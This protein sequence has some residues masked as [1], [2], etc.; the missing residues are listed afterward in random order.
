MYIKLT[1]INSKK[2][3]EITNMKDQTIQN[4]LSQ[5]KE[6]L[7]KLNKS[8]NTISSYISDLEQYFAKYPTISRENI[9]KYKMTISNLGTTTINRKLTSLKQYN[10]YLFNTNQANEMY[11]LKADYIR[12]QDKGNPTNVSEKDVLKFLERVIA[13]DHIYKSRNIAIIYLMANTGIRREECCN[14]EIANIDLYNYEMKII[15]KGN[16]ERTVDL[17]QKAVDVINAYLL[18]RNKHK[19]ANS[20]YLFLSERAMKLSKETINDIFDEYSTPKCKINPHSLRHNWCSTMLENGILSLVEVK[21]QAGHKSL[22]TTELYTHARH[23][24]IKQKIKNY[25]IG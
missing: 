3:K 17:N 10:E 24:K 15:G 21:N 14:L 25:S 1:N 2:V 20:P 13:K 6:Y 9:T 22:C 4:Q 23:D 5:Y 7:T 16:K 18:D 11:I 19:Y 8:A 12:I